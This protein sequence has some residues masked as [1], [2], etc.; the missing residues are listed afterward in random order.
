MLPN[1]NPEFYSELPVNEIGLSKLFGRPH[2]FNDL[3]DD[4]HVIITDIEG[5]TEA[6]SQ[7]RH[8]DI[9][10]IATESIVAVLNIIYKNSLDIPFFFGGDGATFIVPSNMLSQVIHAL[11][12]HSDNILNNFKLRLRVGHVTVA[13]IKENGF[14]LT[15]AKT[16]TSTLLSIPVILG[17]GINYAE[18]RIKGSEYL[19]G[20]FEKLNTEV[21]LQGMQCRWDQ[22]EPPQDRD[23][24]VSLLIVARSEKLQPEA[25]SKVIACI[26][27]IYGNVEKRKA[28]TISKLKLLADFS[29]IKKEVKS[30]MKKRIF[31]S[32][33]VEWFKTLIGK[34]YFSSL[35]GKQ[36]LNTLIQLTDDLVLDGKINT[37]IS[38]TKEQRI[39]LEEKLQKM[40]DDQMIVFGL[41]TSNSAI[42]SCYVRDMDLKH[43]HFIDGAN[44]GYTNAGSILKEKLKKVQ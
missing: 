21:D 43:I 30:Q 18:K 1:N 39:L 6:I 16:R 26:D 36:Y 9:N 17:D 22:I 25:F 11:R 13:E 3:P 35:K 24:I 41:F 34:F 37:V 8:H 38:G 15:I 27:E 44:G 4:W 42:M 12:T 28:V 31:I 23:E 40:E 33:A 14:R 7:G 20:N 2:L 19:L 32:T 10:M 5:S 29:R